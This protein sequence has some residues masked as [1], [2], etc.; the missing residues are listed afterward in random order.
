MNTVLHIKTFKEL[1]TDELYELLRVRSD[2]FVVEQNCVYQDLDYDDQKALHLWLEA[3]GKILAQARICPAGTHMENLS[4]GRVISTVRG[5]GYGKQITLATID[6]AVQHFGATSIDIEAQEYAK[7]FY[8]DVGFHQTSERFMLDGIPHVQMR[9]NA[10]SK[11][12]K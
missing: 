11:E 5:Q 1:T 8:E 10:K 12:G 2:V 7:A 6:A 4:I 9:W 3:E